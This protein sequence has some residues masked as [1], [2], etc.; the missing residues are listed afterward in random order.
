MGQLRSLS[1]SLLQLIEPPIQATH[2]PPQTMCL[3]SQ[4]RRRGD[5]GCRRKTERPPQRQPL[6]HLQVMLLQPPQRTLQATR[7]RRSPAVAD[8][9]MDGRELKRSSLLPRM[10]RGVARREVPDRGKGVAWAVVMVTPPANPPHDDVLALEPPPLPLRALQPPQEDH[11]PP[12][13]PV[14]AG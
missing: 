8:L 2:R 6:R 14:A 13:A 1:H 7:N 10:A 12:T 5:P 11:V 4:P 9:D 3:P